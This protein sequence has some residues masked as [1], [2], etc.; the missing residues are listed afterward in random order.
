MPQTTRSV[1]MIRPAHFR[2][3]PETAPSN[4]FQHL[5]AVPDRVAHAAAILEFTRVVSAL[6]EAGID[7]RVFDDAPV[8]IRPDAI[9]P[10]NWFTTHDDGTVVLYPMHAPSRRAEV[11]RDVIAELATGGFTVRRVVD[12]TG[13]AEPGLALEGTGSMVLD[14]VNRVAYACL[15]ARTHRAVLDEFCSEVGFEPCVFSALDRR[16]IPIYHT[17]VQMWIGTRA[18]A[19]CLDAIIDRAEREAVRRGLAAGDRTVIELSHDQ[20]AAFAGNALELQAGDGS[21]VIAMSAQASAA[22]NVS[23]R[24]TLKGYAR[25]VDA[26]IATIERCS[27]GSVRCMLAEIF[28]PREQARE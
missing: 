6:T 2:S 1:L 27:G 18:A 17:N 25:I 9:F 12:L 26:D 15:S 3:N 14:R 7:V 20:V 5:E 19:V 4:A 8:P 10:N 13:H 28:L 21:P 11:R 22:L 23:Q 24:E 16:G